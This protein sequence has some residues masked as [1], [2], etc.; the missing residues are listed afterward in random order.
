L[1]PRF[2]LGGDDTR[3]GARYLGA[4]VRELRRLT[5][6]PP[7]T[8][9]LWAAVLVPLVVGGTAL[10]AIRAPGPRHLDAIGYTLLVVIG[11][12]VLFSH[13]WRVGT[14]AL[15]VA[16][17]GVY[18]IAGYAN[19]PA[20]FAIAMLLYLSVIPEQPWRS[21]AI[22]A[23]TAASVI[24]FTSAMTR[25]PPG[26]EALGAVAW[27][28]VAIGLAHLI[29]LVQARAARRAAAA[30]EVEARR[31][32]VEERLRI[33]R[34]LH[35]VVSHSISVINV[36]A[37]VAAHVMDERP[38]QAREALLAIKAVSKEAL[39]ELRTILGVLR[40]VDEDESLAPAP[41]LADLGVLVDTAS[42]AGLPLR[43]TVSGEARPLPAAVDL[44]AYR[45]LQ[46]GLTNVLRHAGETTAELAVTYGADEVVVEL[47]DDGTG[48]GALAEG[49]HGIGG[50]RER[51]AAV[52]GLLEAGPRPLRG[53]RVRACLPTAAAAEP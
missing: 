8:R 11:G 30:H 33:A 25:R 38:E 49:G 12:A 27:C 39:R 5:G 51:A 26:W 32:L 45:I 19:G 41:G 48:T 16:A 31:R 43:V 6:S 10:A 42:R 2:S 36:Q 29:G 47:T 17:E 44:A 20:A 52:G 37:G 18:S 3:A 14:L 1:T 21:V 22:G 28:A 46:E 35:D 34:E 9:I 24:A 23:G 15:A 40:H 53:F 13:R 50:M 7:L 4:V